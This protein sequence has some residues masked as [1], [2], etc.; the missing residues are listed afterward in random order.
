[1]QEGIHQKLLAVGEPVFDIHKFEKFVITH[2][3][4]IFPSNELRSRMQMRIVGMS[5]WSRM[6][7]QRED[8]DGSILFLVHIQYVFSR[9]YPEAKEKCENAVRL[10]VHFQRKG[11]DCVFMG[12]QYKQAAG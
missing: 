10:P 11:Y 7:Q 6:S 8:L 2:P 5:F 3:T 1:M 4:T 9:L 12:I